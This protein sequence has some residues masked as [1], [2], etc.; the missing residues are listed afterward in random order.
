MQVA[1]AQRLAYVPGVF[2]PVRA[3]AGSSAGCEMV[4][5][6]P[7]RIGGLAYVADRLT[8]Y[9]EA[10]IMVSGGIAIDQL[11][12]ISEVERGSSGL[13]GSLTGRGD[14]PIIWVR[15]RA[16]PCRKCDINRTRSRMQL[17]RNNCRL[18]TERGVNELERV[19]VRRTP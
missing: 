19:G 11:A 7:A 8:V 17:P 2:S 9:P 10:V 1:R 13:G 14:S 15:S 4:K 12:L 18:K 3:F 6:Y 5:L 16:A